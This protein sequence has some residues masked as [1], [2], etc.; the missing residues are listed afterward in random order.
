MTAATVVFAFLIAGVITGILLV[1]FASVRELIV[2][3]RLIRIGSE[4][5]ATATT[6]AALDARDELARRRRRDDQGN[7]EP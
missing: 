2:E 3:V 1:I 4:L 6:A 5:T 7:P